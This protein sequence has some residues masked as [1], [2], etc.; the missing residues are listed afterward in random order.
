MPLTEN[1]QTDRVNADGLRLFVI[2]LII[3]VVVEV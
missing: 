3:S 2:V 1:Q